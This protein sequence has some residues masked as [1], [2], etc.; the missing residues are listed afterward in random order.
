VN[1]V[2]ID[3]SEKDPGAEREKIAAVV[4]V[5]EFKDSLDLVTIT[6]RGLVKRTTLKAYANIRR[7]ASSAWPSKR[8]T[9]C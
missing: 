5:S 1:F 6:A 2:G 8:A 3:P 7:R 4:P 9:P